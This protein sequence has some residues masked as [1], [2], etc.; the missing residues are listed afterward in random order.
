MD[1]EKIKEIKLLIEWHISEDLK[2]QYAT[3]LVVQHTDQEFIISFFEVKNPIVLGSPDEI[4]STFE[5]IGSVRAEC[6]SQIIVTPK[7]MQE[8]IK[9][10]QTNLDTFHSTVK[11]KEGD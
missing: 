5:K 4:K 3:N 9:I 2:S 1:E 11:A 7:R 10:M 8:F 6:I